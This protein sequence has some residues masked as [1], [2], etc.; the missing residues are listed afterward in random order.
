MS[1]PISYPAL[2]PYPSSLPRRDEMSTLDIRTGG[3]IIPR[4]EQLR[5]Y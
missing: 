4:N 2:P 5:H 3:D 1:F